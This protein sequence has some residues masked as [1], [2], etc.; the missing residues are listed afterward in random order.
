MSTDSEITTKD[1]QQMSCAVT[2]RFELSMQVGSVAFCSVNDVADS[3]ERVTLRVRHKTLHT[4][5][6]EPIWDSS[7]NRVGHWRFTPNP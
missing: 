4:T 6:E 3:L 7:G 5:V 2:G 1:M